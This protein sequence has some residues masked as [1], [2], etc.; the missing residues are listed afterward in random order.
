MRLLIVTALTTMFLIVGGAHGQAAQDDPGLPF[1]LQE[2]A[3]LATALSAIIGVLAA[4]IS[5]FFG[6][7]HDYD[8]ELKRLQILKERYELGKLLISRHYP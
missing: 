7:Q 3:G 6:M 2:I 8:N 1:N 4:G 5:R